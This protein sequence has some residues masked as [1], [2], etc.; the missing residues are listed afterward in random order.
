MEYLQIT[1]IHDFEDE[2]VLLYSEI[3]NDRNEIRKI[4]VYKDDSFGLATKNY[5]FGGTR[6]SLEPIPKIDEI[7]E[8]TQFITKTI[9][10]KEFDTI[11]HEY[12][13]MLSN[14]KDGI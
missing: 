5:E 12:Y 10:K 11:W 14:S 7:A 4:E 1:W 13:N 2:P 8:D 3:D 6:L 9:S